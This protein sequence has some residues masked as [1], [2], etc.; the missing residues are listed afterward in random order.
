MTP[1]P[2]PRTV[3][4]LRAIVSRL[5]EECTEYGYSGTPYAASAMKRHE[6]ELL[7]GLD[8]L[9]SELQRKTRALEAI[10]ACI[11]WND[12]YQTWVLL[13]R[14]RAQP[15]LELVRAA[16]NPTEETKP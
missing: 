4:E 16:L 6:S 14:D 5:M 7:A 1:T 3:E 11:H 8:F 9:R 15:A 10:N 12:T 13:G 2:P